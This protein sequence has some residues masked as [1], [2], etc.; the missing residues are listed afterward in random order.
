MIDRA[1]LRARLP[2]VTVADRRG[3][4]DASRREN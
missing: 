2:P 1:L 3:V 4:T